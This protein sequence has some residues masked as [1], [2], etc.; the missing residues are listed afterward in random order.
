MPGLQDTMRWALTVA[1]PVLMFLS[2]LWW[3]GF[4]T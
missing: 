1:C 4:F 3:V 2:V